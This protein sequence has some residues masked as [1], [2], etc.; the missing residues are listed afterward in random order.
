[1]KSHVIAVCLAAVIIAALFGCGKPAGFGE[2]LSG[3]DPT[4]I[5]DIMSS[6]LLYNG[7]TVTVEGKIV[8]ECPTGCWLDL[9]DDSGVLYID[10]NPSGF[11]IPQKVGRKAIIEGE[12]D[13]GGGRVR[14]I[15]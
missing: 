1:M 9:A 15:G 8:R 13:I 14:I 3:G 11:A 4:R 5:V 7:R 12:V 6:P 10:L 2:P